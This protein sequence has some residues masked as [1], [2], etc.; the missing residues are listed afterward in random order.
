MPKTT[1]KARVTVSDKYPFVEVELFHFKRVDQLNN[2]EPCQNQVDIL[3]FLLLLRV[4]YLDQD[5]D[6]PRPDGLEHLVE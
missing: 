1:Y 5:R 3:A 2:F 6:Q 4:E